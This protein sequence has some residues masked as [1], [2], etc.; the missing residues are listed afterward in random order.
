MKTG[1]YS[2]ATRA[3]GIELFKRDK[4]MTGYARRII[5]QTGMRGVRRGNSTQQNPRVCF[6]HSYQLFSLRCDSWLL[7]IHDILA[8]TRCRL[9]ILARTPVLSN[10][11][12]HEYDTV[13]KDWYID[14]KCTLLASLCFV[15]LSE[16]IVCYLKHLGGG[17]RFLA[18]ALAQS[19]KKRVQSLCFFAIAS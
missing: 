12:C 11:N 13:P 19:H 18:Q 16:N 5:R 6:S 1:F 9:C 7:V 15:D 8:T 4:L 17:A 3:D 2:N 14:L 10:T